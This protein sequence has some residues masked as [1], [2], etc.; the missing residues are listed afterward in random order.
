MIRPDENVM[1]K[2]GDQEYIFIDRYLS[3]RNAD[4]AD[5]LYVSSAFDPLL[6][7]YEKMGI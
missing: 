3:G 1:N 5:E 7:G 4:S 2:A 6:L